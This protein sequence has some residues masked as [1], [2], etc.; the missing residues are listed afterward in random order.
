MS[1]KTI[2]SSM[3]TKEQFQAKLLAMQSKFQQSLPGRIEEINQAWQSVKTETAT[4][5]ALEL[6]HRLVH[7]LTGSAGTFA[8][9]QLSND[10]RALEIVL[11]AIND[12]NNNHA[13][14]QEQSEQIES[15][16]ALIIIASEAPIGNTLIHDTLVPVKDYNFCRKV[17]L[18]ED[19]VELNALLSSQ[20]EHFGYVV[21]SIIELKNVENAILNFKPD[22][23]VIDINFPEGSYAGIEE[24]ERFDFMKHLGFDV[25]KIFISARQ[26][27]DARLQVIRAGGKA[28]L[29]KP[30]NIS[31][32]LEKIREFSQS[33]VEDNYQIL[34]VD[35]DSALVDLMRFVLEQAGM[36]VQS[37]LHPKE[38]LEAI[39]RQ[40]PDLI[41]MDVHM[42]WCN[43][44][45]LA[46]VIRQQVSLEGIPI[47]FLSSETDAD[48][49]FT[50]VLKGGDDFLIKPI[51]INRLPV[52]IKAKAQRARALN[53]LMIKDGLTGLY[54]HT[55]IKELIDSEM[56]RSQRS[57]EVFSVIM[58][59]IDH[60]KEVND[61]YGHVVGDQVLRSLSHFL[62]QR[63]R[64][65]DK[66]GRYGGEEFMVLL[67]GT[68][69][70]DAKKLFDNILKD[71]GK[72]QHH[73]L[74]N[75]EFEVTFSAGVISNEITKDIALL[76]EQ[77]DQSL[78]KA[79]EGGRNQVFATEPLSN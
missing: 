19:D 22:I 5:E 44:I 63:L 59:D 23:L 7:T 46:Q 56:Y 42:P 74:D 67:P 52:F 2:E 65:A 37:V 30:L 25:P 49:Q 21:E 12:T 48:V 75:N 27:I 29:S 43:G 11:K 6:L 53:A 55:Y 66:V 18:I 16:L 24:I 15:L 45:E 51:D 60:F 26:D 62:V 64:K 69:L 38:A 47:I 17:M 57:K 8:H 3:S 36:D 13:L 71:F 35:D 54:N 72:I 58:L 76:L 31:L 28:Y 10:S 32:L 73:T 14:T 79:K 1:E 41:L 70:M 34:I 20:L 78:Y 77:V 9:T 61:T 4:K 68:R 39:S 33:S 40:K 50:A